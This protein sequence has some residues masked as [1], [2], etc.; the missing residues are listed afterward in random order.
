MKSKMIK[1]LIISIIVIVTGVSSYVGYNKFFN[2]TASVTTSKFYS[3]IVKTMNIAKTIQATGIAYAGTSSTV[4]PNNNGTISDLTVKVG[5]TVTSDSK[6]FVCSNTDLTKAVTESTKKLTKAKTQ[7][8][9]DKSD[10][11]LAKAELATLETALTSA[12]AQLAIDE[13]AAKVLLANEPSDD[14]VISDANSKIS[15]DQKAITEAITKIS[16]AKKTIITITN[17]ITDDNDLV[18]DATIELTEATAEVSN[19]TVTSPI[20]GLITSVDSSNGNAGKTS[21]GAIIVSDMS[22]MKVKVAVDELDV[23]S[24]AIGQE[25]TIK[26]DALSDKTFTGSVESIAQLGANTNNTTTYDVVV[27]VSDPSGIRLGM[28]ANVTIAIQSNDNAM[29]IPSEALIETNNKKYVRVQD[30][31]NSNS[32]D[33]IN[34]SLTESNSKLVEITT[35]IETEDYIEVT[36]GVTKGQS[37]LV[38]LASS[39]SSTNTQGGMGGSE[40]QGGGVRPTGGQMPTGS[41]A[42]GTTT[43]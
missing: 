4:A 37:L 15:D 16:D 40:R 19:T 35:G 33:D 26:F 24:I 41:K 38:Q 11:T 1:A 2:K 36:K 27:S 29:V 13:N 31:T 10:L 3:S 22:T 42:G 17:K 18:T 32:E 30:T 20:A 28:N 34:T 5:D 6:L 7:L 43:K 12:K 39:S 8:A 25:A 14:K 23:S 9:T 21:E